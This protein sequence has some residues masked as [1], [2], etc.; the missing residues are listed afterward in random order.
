MLTEFA[1]VA[2][3]LVAIWVL[4]APTGKYI[5]NVF[6]GERTILTPLLRP[7]EQVLY[8]IGRVDET[9]EMSWK[10]YASAF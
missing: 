4:A 5:A 7:I 1:Y 8:K 3:L 2:L 9:R 6:R 10:S